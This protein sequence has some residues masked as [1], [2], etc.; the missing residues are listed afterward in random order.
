[1][2]LNSLHD[3]FIEQLGDLYSGEKQLVQALP[4]SR[5]QRPRPSFARPSRV[6][7]QRPS[8]T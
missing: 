6:I 4:G 5:Q 2:T 8:D 1:M 3:V 7:S